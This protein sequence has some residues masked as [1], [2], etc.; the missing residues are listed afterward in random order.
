MATRGVLFALPFRNPET[1]KLVDTI[2]TG[3]DLAE[4][5]GIRLDKARRI[6]Q[7]AQDAA[8]RRLTRE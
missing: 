6:F 8:D 3:H 4:K 7:A 2:I 5:A 1:E